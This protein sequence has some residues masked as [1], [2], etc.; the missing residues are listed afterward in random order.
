MAYGP[1]LTEEQK[2]KIEELLRQGI[3]QERIANIVGCGK[4]SVGEIKRAKEQDEGY[5][6]TFT[7]KVIPLPSS[8]KD[9]SSEPTGESQAEEVTDN[10]WNIHISNTRICTLEQLIEHCK[11]D[12]SVWSVEKFVVNKWEMAFVSRSTTTTY[13]KNTNTETA[14]TEKEAQ[15]VP[16]FQVK[17]FLKKKVQAVRAREE[18]DALRKEALAYSPSFEGFIPKPSNGSG[19]LV[20]FSVYDHHFGSL[21]WGKETDGPDWDNNI[22]METWK[23]AFEHLVNRCRGFNPEKALLVL[24]NDQQ[25]SDNRAGATE[26]LTPQVMD[27]RYHKVY[28]ISKEASKWAI[29][30]LLAEY[31]SVHVVIC[32]GNHDLLASWHLGD[33]LETWYRNCPGVT[34]DNSIPMRKYF[35]YGVVMIM[36]AH[37]HRGKLED[38]DRI[39]STE[40]SE[41]WG[42]T[43]WRE[44]H[45]GDKHHRK[46]IEHK[47]ATIRSLPS[48]RPSCSWSY[49]Y[50]LIGSIRAAEAFV[51]NRNEGLI[52]TSTFS[53]LPPT[54][55]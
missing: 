7:G 45:T 2:L 26:Q 55:E 18:I 43:K 5:S 33:Y 23:K 14:E 37:G 47:G 19:N 38:Y 44:A 17:A 39:M 25:N 21:I 34:I 35:E 10:T 8:R 30:K 4:T 51:W 54:R 53:I 32:P 36:F 42:R 41:M 27:S 24:G 48:L 31:G 52:G 1:R 6:S 49:E 28:T 15:H 40:R 9:S 3:S 20:E 16:L 46:V 29:D 13:G 12:L 22:A 11:I 50:T